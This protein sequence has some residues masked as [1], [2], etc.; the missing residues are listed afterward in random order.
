MVIGLH[1]GGI[2]WSLAVE[3]VRFRVLGQGCH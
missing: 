2:V 1:Y 3:V